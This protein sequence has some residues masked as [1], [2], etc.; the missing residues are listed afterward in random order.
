MVHTFSLTQ[1][2]DSKDLVICKIQKFSYPK[3]PLSKQA[4]GN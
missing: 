2:S 3:G 1:L 4:T